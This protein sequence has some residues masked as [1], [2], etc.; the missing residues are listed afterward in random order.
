MFKM[1]GLS[2]VLIFGILPFSIQAAEQ[3]SEDHD[4]FF[5]NAFLRYVVSPGG[6]CLHFIDKSTG[7]DYGI[8]GPVAKVKKEGRYFDVE[9]IRQQNDKLVLDFASAQVMATVQVIPH[10]RYFI[11]NVADVR[12][13]QE[14]SWFSAI[15]PF[16][17]RGDSMNLFKRV[18]WR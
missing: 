1:Y 7:T 10:V 12:G 15:Y 14:K 13:A 18:F 3:K 16:K 17:P 8:N 4:I 9:G 11:L 5:E 2:A 6:R